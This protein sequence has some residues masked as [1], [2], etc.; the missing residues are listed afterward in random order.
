METFF[1]YFPG[2]L[3]VLCRI[4]AF[5]VSAPIFSTRNI[6]AMF[7]VGIA[8]FVAVITYMAIHDKSNI[9]FDALY[10]LSVLKEVLVGLLL[11]F[12]AY[13]FFIVAQIAGSFID[14]QMGFIMANLIDPLT[15]TSVPVIGNLKFIIATL[16]FLTFNGHHYLIQAIMDSYAWVPLDHN[17]LAQIYAGQISEFLVRS[18]TTTFMLAF[19]LAAPMVVALFL[20][21]T[22]L[23]IL[24]KTAPQ[25]NVFVVGFPL[26]ILL[27][28]LLLILLVPGYLPLFRSLFLQMFEALRGLMQMTG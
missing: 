1:Q 20:A 11:G 21:D 12:L 26:K 27:G 14:M 15:G 8:F 3:L 19:Q 5:L 28:F 2:F 18:F 22:G 9:P 6:P 13:L 16:L 24:A 7:K 10:L 17:L 4:S 23:G 25:F